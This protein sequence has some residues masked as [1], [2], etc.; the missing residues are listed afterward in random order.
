MHHV[1]VY[2]KEKLPI[3]QWLYQQFLAIVIYSSLWTAAGVASLAYFVESVLQL[4][5]DWRAVALIFAAALLP[6]NLDR[7]LDSYVQPIPDPKVQAYF[8]HPRTWLLLLGPTLMVGIL[9]YH[10]PTQVQFVSIGGVAPLIYG[11]PLLPL[12]RGGIRRW[13][14]LKDIPGAKA[15]IVAGIITYAVL[16]IPLAYA[17]VKPD[18]IATLLAL[19]LLIL[20]GTNSHLF[21]VRDV[22]SDQKKGVLTLPLLVGVQGN[23]CIWTGLNLGLLILLKQFWTSEFAI[24]IPV[25]VLPL[26]LV[27][28]LFIWLLHPE[29]PRNIYNIGL[30]GCLFLPAILITMTQI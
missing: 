6:Y 19:F 4:P 17:A 28:L 2:T 21:D 12:K 10:A 13:Y 3:L 30:D 8:R 14:R 7:L 18:S 26:T 1:L 23:R 27:N 5:H 11:L 29:T 20:T 15:W 24:F 22:T 25:I 9:L 16:A